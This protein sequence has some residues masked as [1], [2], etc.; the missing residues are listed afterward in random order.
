MKGLPL[1]DGWFRYWILL[2]LIGLIPGGLVSQPLVDP[3]LDYRTYRTIHFAIHYPAGYR[4]NAL[5]LG[6]LAEKRYRV[7]EYRYRSGVDVTNIILIPETDTVNAFASTYVVNRVALYVQSPTP[8]EF[9]RY[10]LWQDH[11]FTHE[12]THILNLYPYEGLANVI[13]RIFAGLPPNFLTPTGLVEG[14]PVYEESQS[15]KGRLEDPLTNMVIRAAIL[16]NRFPSLE[17]IM[18]GTHRWP[19]GS[20]SYL[21]GGRFV[22]FLRE[23]PAFQQSGASARL[24]EYFLSEEL[25]VLSAERLERLGYPDIQEIYNLFKEFETLRLEGRY[26]SETPFKRLTDTGFS[27]KFLQ[28]HN[29]RLYYFGSLS[30]DYGIFSMPLLSSSKNENGSSKNPPADSVEEPEALPKVESH[31]LSLFRRSRSSAGFTFTG[32]FERESDV[33]NPEDQLLASQES[34]PD[35]SGIRYQL[36]RSGGL[37][38]QEVSPDSRILFPSARGDKLAYIKREDPYRYLMVARIRADGQLQDERVILSAD[39]HGILTNSV[40]S[41]DASLVIG[42]YRQN[43]TGHPVLMGCST[44]WNSG[45]NTGTNVRNTKVEG[46][47][48]QIGDC[49][50]LVSAPGQIVQ[51]SF[52]DDGVLFSSDRTGRYE[53]YRLN[54]T[55][56]GP[57]S[58]LLL[59]EE[60]SVEQLS[61]SATGLFYPVSEGTQIFALRYFADGYDVVSLD[62]QDL[63]N[64]DVSV[65]FDNTDTSRPMS[66][67]QLPS[68]LS[69]SEDY[70]GP[71]EIRPYFAGFLF[72]ISAA[73]SGVLAYDPL[74]RHQIGLGIGILDETPYFSATYSYNRFSHSLNLSY[75]RSSLTKRKFYCDVP[76]GLLVFLCLADTY[77]F[78]Y[79]EASIDRQNAGRE[80]DQ[81]YSVGLRHEKHRNSDSLASLVFPERDVNLSSLFA[82]Y[83][84]SN[85]ISFP[86][87][88]SLERGFSLYGE[89]GFYPQS[90]VILYDDYSKRKETAE[91]YSV[92]AQAELFL[93]FF[94]DHHVPYLAANARW[95]SGKNP[96]VYRVRLSSYMRG[97]IPEASPYGRGALV[98]TA[99]YRFP[100]FWLSRRLISWWP[101]LGL[102]Y[103]S[104]APFYDYGQSFERKVYRDTWNRSYGF[105]TDIGLN[106]FY[107]PLAIRLI[108]A[109]G[110]GPA[111]ETSYGFGLLLGAEAS[112]QGMSRDPFAR[113]LQRDY[114]ALNRHSQSNGHHSF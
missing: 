34:F 39:L 77:Q 90:W 19:L 54:R 37:S 61:E 58:S 49:R 74:Q 13:L 71:L 36:Y 81:E 109:R 76:R 108:Y 14:F 111:G 70:N 45:I 96:E 27:K 79:A 30:S 75:A 44:P 60:V 53:L 47:K 32:E 38:L 68:R 56:P 67:F 20:T 3:S 15:G 2:F 1:P 11:L 78:E 55:S 87:S 46:T 82:G 29:G 21:F 97:L 31:S 41:P 69:G 40:L 103:I 25:P 91:F 64:R 48:S 6:E 106:I 63:L 101:S 100:L 16:E 102:R 114:R 92:E 35:Y 85:A 5:R 10:D 84:I 98:L 83:G 112:S 18:A 104:L 80:V 72:G 105:Y 95:T 50:V 51:P 17:E 12:Y 89:A 62:R 22:Q 7:L 28:I 66:D 24:D 57:W 94:F 42:I 73:E 26:S 99:E 86:E 8:G 9:S 4:E 110:E 23:Y 33:V 59:Q 88:I 93:P 107:F 113:S 65:S 52:S 43:G